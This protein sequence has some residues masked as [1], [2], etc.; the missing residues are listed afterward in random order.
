L[1]QSQA[2]KCMSTRI[3]QELN[4]KKLAELEAQDICRIVKSRQI[5]L[6][7]KQNLMFLSGGVVSTTRFNEFCRS[8]GLR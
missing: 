8:R 7:S 6:P 4:E 3:I 1:S 5:E 2:V